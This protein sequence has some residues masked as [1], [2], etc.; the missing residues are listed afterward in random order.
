M[1]SYRHR[2]LTD[3]GAPRKT[4]LT[5]EITGDTICPWC[6]IGKR[7]LDKALSKLNGK[8][9]DINIFWKPF[10]LDPTLPAQSVDQR[11]HYQARLGDECMNAMLSRIA[12]VGKD[13]ELDLS[14]GGRIGKTT[15][16]HRLI[17]WATKFGQQE[18]VV[19]KLFQF[20]F[21]KERDLTDHRT[22]ADVAEVATLDRSKAIAFL[23][24]DEGRCEVGH[25]VQNANNNGI[26]GVPSFNINNR[27]EFCGAQEPEYFLDIFKALALM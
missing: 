8:R 18:Q 13:E 11:K 20:F 23:R 27:F 4:P 7:R 25:G 17:T 19:D 6:F 21:E 26:F 12:E 22:L 2:R 5:I 14:F 15:D 3:E 10:Y 1:S 16:S 24:S 9:V